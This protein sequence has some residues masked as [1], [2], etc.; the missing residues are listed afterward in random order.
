M[1]R[2]I[3]LRKHIRGL[4]RGDARTVPQGKWIVLRIFRIGHYSEY[5]N[6]ERK[7]AIGGPKWQ[8]DDFLVRAISRPGSIISKSGSASSAPPIEG[9]TPLLNLAGLDSSDT[10]VYA[11]EV[12]PELPREPAE[13]DRIYEIQE[14]ARNR[15]PS[16][17]LH[18]LA[19]YDVLAVLPD[20]G[21]VGRAE[22]YL[23]YARKQ[24]GI[25]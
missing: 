11:I 8:Y 15:K 2:W 20:H 10:M 18:A 16:P 6:E 12:L 5:W 14:Y 7:E 3:D 4:T 19:M 24:S 1:P 17:P 13:G 25:S 23:V 22:S 9:L 21:D